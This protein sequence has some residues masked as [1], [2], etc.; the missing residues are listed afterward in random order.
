[1]SQGSHQ[2]FFQTPLLIALWILLALVIGGPVFL[3][4][5]RRRAKV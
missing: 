5:M 2:I 1:M 3:K 4:I